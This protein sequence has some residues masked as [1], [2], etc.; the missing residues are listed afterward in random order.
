MDQA[1]LTKVNILYVERS[2][3]QAALDNL[4]GGGRIIQMLI[5]APENIPRPAAT[6]STV[7]WQYPQAMADAI[8][9]ELQGRINEINQQFSEMG[10]TGLPQT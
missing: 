6:V 7:G 4:V 5:A 1:D 3:I 2:S 8:R 9:S 10:I